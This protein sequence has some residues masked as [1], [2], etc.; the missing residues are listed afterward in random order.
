[1]GVEI[2]SIGPV[3][4]LSESAGLLSANGCY[5]FRDPVAAAK[6]V[7]F[8][9]GGY[10][11]FVVSRGER[12]GAEEVEAA[13]G[14]GRPRPRPDAD[15]LAASGF[16]E[17]RRLFETASIRRK[18]REHGGNVARTVGVCRDPGP[19]RAPLSRTGAGNAGRRLRG[20][21]ACSG[22]D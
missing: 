3:R 1:M 9:T 19:E 20:A 10:R 18:L 4:E 17:A 7:P 15:F 22:T 16:R 11:L 21:P 6:L 12:V 8:A 13:L 2:G 14:S 5:S